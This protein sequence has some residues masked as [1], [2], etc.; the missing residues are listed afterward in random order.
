MGEGKTEKVS[1]GKVV[2]AMILKEIKK[3]DFACK[4]DAIKAANKLLKN[5]NIIDGKRN[6]GYCQNSLYFSKRFNVYF[7]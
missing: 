7:C 1:A 2:K 3:R 5:P 4:T 6:K